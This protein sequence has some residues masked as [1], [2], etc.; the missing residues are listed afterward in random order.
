MKAATDGKGISVFNVNLFK[1][2]VQV[3]E[4]LGLLQIPA[5]PSG[6]KLLSQIDPT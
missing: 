2:L 4:I 3:N 1:N 5:P 6:I